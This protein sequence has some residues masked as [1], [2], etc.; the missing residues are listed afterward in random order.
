MMITWVATTKITFNAKFDMMNIF[1][2]IDS[3]QERDRGACV[4]MCLKRI[5]TTPCSI[6]YFVCNVMTTNREQFT[7][8]LL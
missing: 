4:C 6:T 2:K 5:F 7:F 8:L 1:R 3:N